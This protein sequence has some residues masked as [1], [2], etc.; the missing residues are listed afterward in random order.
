M[1]RREFI[2]NGIKFLAILTFNPLSLVKNNPQVSDTQM[3][4]KM[5]MVR[6]EIGQFEHIRLIERP[7]PDNFSVALKKGMLNTLNQKSK[8]AL[9]NGLKGILEIE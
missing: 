7:I 4:E 5:P 9:Q 3:M 8:H 2:T 1:N 6:G